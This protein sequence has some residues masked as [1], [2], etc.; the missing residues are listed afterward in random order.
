MST[1]A[2]KKLTFEQFLEQYP[3]GYGIYE[4][5]NGEIVQVEPIRAHKN[6]A[7]YLVRLF[8]REIE[9]LDLDYIV[10]KDIVIRTVTKD[11]QEQGRNPDVSV[12][13]ASLW[14]SNP[15]TYGALI[16]PPQLVVEVTSSNWEDDYV[17]KLD[18]Y[19]RLGIPEYW[20][21]DYWAIAS[22]TYLGYPKVPT[23]LV[24]QL[25][26]GEYQHQTFKGSERI[27]SPTFPELKLTMDEII[28]AS[29]SRK[30]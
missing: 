27:I 11:G 4:L 30:L 22:R 10:D 8:D 14:N 24:Y 26:N 2:L 5:V 25:V 21:V 18:E 23:V 28:T 20:I 19:Q 29:L 6:V 13:S 17:D 9:R 16:E 15:L 1:T 12:A 3:D 7:R